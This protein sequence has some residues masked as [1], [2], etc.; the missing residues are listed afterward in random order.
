MSNALV[1]QGLMRSSVEEDV[2]VQQ[3]AALW[4]DILNFSSRSDLCFGMDKR[5]H[6]R[7]V[8]DEQFVKALANIVRRLDLSTQDQS[9]SFFLFFF[10]S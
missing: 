4:T 2:H 8:L 9:G 10:F 1:W 3:Y 5:L 7:Q 6:L